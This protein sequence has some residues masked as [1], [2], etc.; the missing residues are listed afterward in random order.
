MSS[1]GSEK[2]QGASQIWL[3]VCI[4]L[5]IA[6]SVLLLLASVGLGA[7]WYW[8]TRL[9]PHPKSGATAAGEGLHWSGRVIATDINRDGT[10]D[11]VGC[12]SVDQKRYLGG[13]DGKT[14]QRIW[15]SPPLGTLLQAD[16]YIAFG[17][18]SDQA[19]V[20]DFRPQVYVLDLL[21]GSLERVVKLSDK[22]QSICSQSSGRHEAWIEVADDQ[23][24]LLD[25][26]TGS[27]TLAPRPTW[28]KPLAARWCPQRVPG[29]HP[30]RAT[31]REETTLDEAGFTPHTVLRDGDTTYV[32]GA[33]HSGTPVP[34]VLALD[35]RTLTTIWQSPVVPDRYNVAAFD[36]PIM[37]ASDRIY[38]A[39]E[40]L[41]PNEVHVVALDRKTGARSLDFAVPESTG[42][43]GLAEIVAT[44][45]R[46]YVPYLAQL[47]VF[48]IRGRRLATVGN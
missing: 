7:A 26:T 36:G 5:G 21:T 40:T 48:D 37:L 19:V 2:T 28:C 35:S 27:T 11:F 3:R 30:C 8:W 9:G 20:A 41:E 46:I 22:A 1:R 45:Q 31:S 6:L 32:A 43:W 47:H 12:Y 38:A 29:D 10:E 24:V 16:S 25:L 34:A 42:A 13:F 18:A 44:K 17:V 4:G 33:K 15:A 39:Y 23:H 14:L